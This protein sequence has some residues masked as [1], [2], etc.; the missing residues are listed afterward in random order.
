MEDVL[1]P[2]YS[3]HILECQGD[4]FMQ[5]QHSHFDLYRHHR[6]AKFPISDLAT[7]HYY[8]FRRGMQIDDLSI[9][10]WFHLFI[11][12]AHDTGCVPCLM[13]GAPFTG[14]T[15]SGFPPVSR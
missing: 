5:L 3:K 12:D 1:T 7:Y 2:N 10:Y 4:D 13:L 11:P 6:L 14:A 9:I 15:G 8:Q